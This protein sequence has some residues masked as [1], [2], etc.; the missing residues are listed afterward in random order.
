MCIRMVRYTLCIP[1]VPLPGEMSAVWTA[2]SLSHEPAE[3][4][5]SPFSELGK[6]FDAEV[7]SAGEEATA[8]LMCWCSGPLSGWLCGRRGDDSRLTQQSERV[9]LA[10]ASSHQ[11]WWNILPFDKNK[12][13]IWTCSLW[14]FSLVS[15]VCSSKQA[16]DVK[17]KDTC[18]ISFHFHNNTFI[19]IY[20][21]EGEGKLTLAVDDGFSVSD[22]SALQSK[23]TGI[24][25]T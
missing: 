14:D 3:S 9:S 15:L 16:L 13:Q 4:V 8:P 19:V 22:S 10:C 5:L 6:L 25:T 17:W 21:E 11:G 7:C 18:T 20:Y 23:N 2:L 12:R 1:L 24:W